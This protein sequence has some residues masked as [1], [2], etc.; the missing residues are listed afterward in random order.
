[1]SYPPHLRH[2][3]D[4]LDALWACDH[5]AGVFPGGQAKATLPWPKAR[6]LTGGKLCDLDLVN[7]E[8]ANQHPAIDLVDPRTLWASQPYVLHSGV[9]YYL[10]HDWFRTGRTYADQQKPFNRLPVI[11]RRSDGTDV[12]LGGH[13]RSCAALLLGQ[14]VLARVVVHPGRQPGERVDLRLPSLAVGDWSIAESASTAAGAVRCIA[15]GHRVVVA[16]EHAALTTIEALT[17]GGNQ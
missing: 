5:V 10:G 16:T 4:R 11:E 12:I 13:H 8:F 3:T 1:M 15:T 6:R 7:A 17:A 2:H 14:P 9:T